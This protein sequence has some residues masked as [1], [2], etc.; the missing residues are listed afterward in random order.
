MLCSVLQCVAVC[1]SVLQCVAVCC[2]VLQCDVQ[3][4]AV[5]CAMCYGVWQY[6]TVCCSTL[7]RVT[8]CC[9]VC[10]AVCCSVLQCV[11]VCC[12]VFQR[13]AEVCSA[14]SWITTI[15]RPHHDKIFTCDAIVHDPSFL[16]Y[17]FI[18]RKI[19][20]CHHL[21]YVIRCG[22]VDSLWPIPAKEASFGL[23]P[24]FVQGSNNE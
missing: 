21:V 7:H 22:V 3:C 24:C 20:I 17:Q 16:S 19:L 13:V 8:A 2:S 5:C 10:C 15:S 4:V 9:A 18:Q 11:E 23:E 12:N 1:C 6:V 14:A